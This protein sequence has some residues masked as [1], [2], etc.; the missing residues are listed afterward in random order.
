MRPAPTGCGRC[1]D[2]DPPLLLRGESPQN[3]SAEIE[4]LDIAASETT[5]KAR[6]T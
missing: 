5:R 3:R 1:G 6:A 4:R 2:L